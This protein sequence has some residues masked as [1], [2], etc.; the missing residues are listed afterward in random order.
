EADG[1]RDQAASRLSAEQEEYQSAAVEIE[2]LESEVEASR[3]DVFTTLSQATTLAHAIENAAAARERAQ[4][5]LA[6]LDVEESDL[7]VEAER[8][9]QDRIVGDE[10][11]SGLRASLTRARDARAALE[12]DLMASRAAHAS[13]SQAL[14]E[15]EHDR[16]AS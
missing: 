11:L 1:G 15:R 3:R 13:V 6:R 12:Q 10:Q 14:R 16:A 9:S 8:A 2:A 5:T 4:E 7:R